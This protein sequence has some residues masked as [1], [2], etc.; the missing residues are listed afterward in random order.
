MFYIHHSV[1]IS[2]QLTF[3]SID[4]EKIIEAR[5]GKLFAREPA[6]EKIPLGILRRMGKA[7]RIGVG[8]AME[9]VMQQPDGIVIG[10][11]EG[12][13]EDCIKFLNQIIEYQEGVLTPTNFVQSTTNAIAAQI[14]LLSSNKGYNCTHAHRGLS[15]EN[16]MIDVYMLLAEGLGEKILLGG[17]D[18]ISAY[19]YNIERLGGTYKKDPVKGLELYERKTP[20]TIAGEGSAMFLVSRNAVSSIAHVHGIKT[21]HTRDKARVANEMGK[22]LESHK[23]Q[24]PKV[25]LLIS[26]EN[27]DDRVQEYYSVCEEALGKTIPVARF[28]HV[29]GEYGTASSFALWLATLLLQGYSLPAHFYKYEAPATPVSSILLYNNYKGLQH[30]FILVSDPKNTSYLT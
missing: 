27:G 12:G 5:D 13:L 6:Y 25:G 23:K 19:N 24:I 18:E 4:M 2:P 21:I 29:S 9:L 17:V 11:S 7:A 3:P 28:K 30:S 22:F 15:F 14:G 8:A 1:C 16:A 20:G 26:G 10:T